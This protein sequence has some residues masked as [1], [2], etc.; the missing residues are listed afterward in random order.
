M[1][2]N[3][4]EDILMTDERRR[5]LE[6]FMKRS[7]IINLIEIRDKIERTNENHHE[8]KK[9]TSIRFTFNKNDFVRFVYIWNKYDCLKK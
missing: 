9:R 7:H 1:Y 8:I 2:Q 6:S 5:L 3:E 4:N